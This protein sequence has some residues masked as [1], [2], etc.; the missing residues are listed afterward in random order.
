[1]VNW[2][3]PWFKNNRK[4]AQSNTGTQN[5]IQ[6]SRAFSEAIYTCYILS[7]YLCDNMNSRS[8]P[9]LAEYTANCII[10]TMRPQPTSCSMPVSI[11]SQSNACKGAQ[12]NLSQVGVDP[13]DV[14]AKAS[15]DTS[16]VGARAAGAP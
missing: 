13:G 10:K 2:N 8:L 16:K 5:F 6:L 3:F 7:R 12:R 9:K 4:L 15:V 14:V 1:M 11:I